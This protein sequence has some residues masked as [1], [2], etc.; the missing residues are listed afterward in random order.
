MERNDLIVAHSEKIRPLVVSVLKKHEELSVFEMLGNLTTQGFEEQTVRSTVIAMLAE[1]QIDMT[2]MRKLRL[3]A[4]CA[5]AA[6][7]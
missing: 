4:L 3:N 7:A 6:G 2:P 5:R 1:G